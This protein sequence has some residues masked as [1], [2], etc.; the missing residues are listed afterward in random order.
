MGS[1]NV[2]KFGSREQR[3]K[4]RSET[5]TELSSAAGAAL[6]QAV[7]PVAR[8][9][10]RARGLGH[11]FP[12]WKEP[13]SPSFHVHWRRH[14]W[15]SPGPP[16]A[17]IPMLD[18]TATEWCTM[19][20]REGLRSRQ[21]ERVLRWR[22]QHKRNKPWS[23]KTC[24]GAAKRTPQPDKKIGPRPLYSLRASAFSNGIV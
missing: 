5:K 24:Q 12:G 9:R 20:A 22:H 1:A 6:H 10:R 21:K 18:N 14:K 7:L 3:K 15:R 11:G 13:L 4:N 2:C 17:T 23:P 19:R 16:A 8:P